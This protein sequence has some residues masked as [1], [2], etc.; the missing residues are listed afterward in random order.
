MEGCANWAKT[1]GITS[2]IGQSAVDKV[3]TSLNPISKIETNENINKD[4][5]EAAKCLL[6]HLQNLR[7]ALETL[8]TKNATKVSDMEL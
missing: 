7:R 8:S 2:K 1:S 5:K 3:T 4:I 6:S